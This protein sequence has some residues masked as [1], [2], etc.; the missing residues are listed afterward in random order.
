LRIVKIEALPVSLPID[1]FSDRYGYYDRFDY[2]VVKI[3]TDNG[4]TGLGEASPVHVGFYG[5]TQETVTLVVEKCIRPL[6]LGEDPLNIEKIECLLDLA[7]AGNSCAKAAVDVAL[8]DVA[9]KSLGVPVHA[10]LGGLFRDKAPVG[11]EL[12]I[13]K[14]EDVGKKILRFLE[15]RVKTIKLHVGTTPKEDVQAIT[16]LYDAVGNSAVIRA[17]AN[18]AYSTAQ[19]IDVMKKVEEYELEYFEQPVSRW[20]IDGLATI[21]RAVNT[22]ICVDES[23]WTIEDA[24]QICSKQAADVINIKI[25]RVGGL[26]KAKKIADIAAASFLKCHVGS[27]TEFGVGMA[28]K[29]HLAVSLNNAS[30]AAAGEFTEILHLKDNIVKEP[31]IWGDGYLRPT[32]RPGLGIELEEEKMRLYGSRQASS[33]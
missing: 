30:C 13:T 11:F 28:A 21:K 8:H 18:G 22:P 23:V 6:V 24:M 2:V 9:A 4:F 20:N 3:H 16:A 15:M 27:E 31:V 26:T 1:P 12:G 5:E 29:A 19:A 25:P 17:D 32:G 10:L 33:H 14:P 7:V